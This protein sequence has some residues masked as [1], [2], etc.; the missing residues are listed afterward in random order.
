MAEPRLKVIQV[1]TRLE[2]GGS[3]A[4]TLACARSIS[5][6][7]D[8]MLICGVPE[9]QGAP[10]ESAGGVRLLEIKQLKRSISPL[11]DLK[12]FRSLLAAYRREKPDIVHTHTSKAG[13]LGR[14]AAWAYNRTAD[15][16]C[17]IIH[18][19][20]GHVLFG[21]FGSWKT[22]VF[23]AAER[24]TARVTDRL[25]ALS[26]GE[27]Q[28][29]QQAGIGLPRQ[30]SVIPSGITF[31]SQMEIG[32]C[33]ERG[34]GL[35]AAL[36][37]A[38]EQTVIGTVA[39]LEPV[40]GVRYLIAAAPSV[41]R[42]APQARFLVVGDGALRH[43]LEN[44]ARRL[45]VA[46]QTIFTGHK[47]HPL[48]WMAAMDVYVQPSLN[49]GLGRTLVEAAVLGLPAVASRV[50]GIPDIVRHGRTG[51]LVPP[52]DPAALAEA[53]CRLAADP[54]LRQ[55]LGAAARAHVLSPDENGLP[56]FSADAMI[57]QLE[58]LYGYSIPNH[59]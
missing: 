57:I 31:P 44:L 48:D 23:A 40:K 29:S 14:W 58:Q 52:G 50:C 42:A 38:P 30:W 19:P 39:R 33:R 15:K 21:Y 24:L 25:V 46:E 2:A 37:L 41:L 59:A 10:C 32:L 51:L 3:S 27:M 36:G 26:Q 35:R 12:A 7:F 17:L 45:G 20:H 13:I 11:D 54:H 22:W 49:E 6:R 28:E 47:D 9:A 55:E 16:P 53:V 5:E 18:T 43:Q 4:N 1:I 34:H 8:S 56:R